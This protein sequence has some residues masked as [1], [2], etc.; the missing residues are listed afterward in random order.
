M[1]QVKVVGAIIR[2]EEGLILCALRS[3]E[4]SLPNLWEFQVVRLKK[5]SHHNK[6]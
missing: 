1:K 6:L 5:E 2:N 3:S 4:M